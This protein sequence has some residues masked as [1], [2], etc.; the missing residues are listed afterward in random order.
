MKYLKLF[1][2]SFHDVA[3]LAHIRAC[4]AN[5]FEDYEEAYNY[6]IQPFDF[7]LLAKFH[8][9]HPDSST[10]THGP[11]FAIHVVPKEYRKNRIPYKKYFNP[12]NVFEQD[13][14]NIRSL[15]DKEELQKYG[16]K[17]IGIYPTHIGSD[18]NIRIEI[19]KI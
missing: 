6:V 10:A 1:E 11:L 12:D 14:D 7:R 13:M 9:M 18:K 5:I 2:N 16:Y 4:M 3:D 15:I 8:P 19:A 17:Y